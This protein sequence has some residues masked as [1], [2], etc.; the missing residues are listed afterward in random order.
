MLRSARELQKSCSDLS[1]RLEKSEGA[2]GIE[3]AS[4]R[5]LTMRL[6]CPDRILSAT[7]PSISS[8]TKARYVPQLASR[9]PNASFNDQ[10]SV[11]AASVNA[12]LESPSRSASHA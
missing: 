12:T 7:A 1:G 2:S 6:C 10:A 3:L 8:A 11:E 9:V 5:L 4:L